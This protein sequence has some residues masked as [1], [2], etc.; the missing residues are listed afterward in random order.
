MNLVINMKTAKSLIGIVLLIAIVG[1]GYF[2]WQSGAM[3]REAGGQTSY[4]ESP[5]TPEEVAEDVRGGS[6]AAADESGQSVY[7]NTAYGFSFTYP[8]GLVIS[9]VADLDGDVILVREPDGEREF[10]IYVM[11]F[12]EPGPITQERIHQDL[13][14]LQVENPQQVLTGGGAI[15]ALIFNGQSED[16]GSTRE[17]WF[18]AGG[19]LYQVITHEGMDGFV[20]PILETLRFQ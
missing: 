12:D 4:A 9:S 7:T 19:N 3:D 16:F 18:V 17:V 11:S 8:D 10:Q 20:G 15:Q 5:P 13:P 6:V 2:L 14:E 1:G